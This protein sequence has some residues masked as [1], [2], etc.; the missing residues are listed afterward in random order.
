M[1]ELSLGLA[2][3]RVATYHRHHE[4]GHSFVFNNTR[5]LQLMTGVEC[6]WMYD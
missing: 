3:Q 5:R 6:L 2:R 4:T 1:H